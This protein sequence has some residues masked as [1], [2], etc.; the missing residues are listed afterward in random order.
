MNLQKI[1]ASLERAADPNYLE[2]MKLLGVNTEQAIG[3][4]MPKLKLLAKNIGKNH[5]MAGELWSLG[6]H[7]GRILAGLVAEPDKMEHEEANEWV[8]NLQSWDEVDQLCGYLF[9]KL[10]YVEDL[11]P[12]WIDHK[13]PLVKRAGFVLIVATCIHHKKKEDDH[14][15]QYF[16]AIEDHATDKRNY[17]KRA[18]NWAL[19]QIGKRTI[20][21]NR[22]AVKVAEKLADK[23]NA[24]ASWI[25]KNALKDIQSEEV[26]ERLN[27]KEEKRLK[28]L[29]KK[30]QKEKEKKEAEKKKAAKKAEKK[31]KK[32]GKK[33]S[34]KTKKK[35]SKVKKTAKK[36]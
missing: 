5:E 9:Q 19:R 29:E 4:R 31:A 23:K 35:K 6:H 11:I 32:A 20:Q 10:P 18:V 3:V 1:K 2:Q 8:E 25:G 36:K 26:L 27:K 34:A 28:K 16:D 15:V 7:E 24:T 22:K 21:L 30:R 33:S 13:D 12:E 17:V 14:F